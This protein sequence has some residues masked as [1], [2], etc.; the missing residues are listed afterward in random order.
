MKPNFPPKAISFTNA[1][2]LI[3]I[4]LLTKKGEYIITGLQEDM[5]N[6]LNQIKKQTLPNRKP[7]RNYS[8]KTKIGKYQKY[9]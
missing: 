2:R 4:Y 1:L 7:N 9:K 8:R 5:D 6:L 3:R